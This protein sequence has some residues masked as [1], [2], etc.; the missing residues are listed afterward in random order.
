M[1]V[2]ITLTMTYFALLIGLGV[3]IANLLKKV[4]IPDTFFLLL[5]GL[6]IGP[7]VF[8]NPLVTQYIDMTLVNVE[9]MGAVP[10]FLRV[11]ALILV[12]FTGTFNLKWKIFQRFSNV[13]VNLAFLGVFFTTIFTGLFA[14]ILFGFD[15]IQSLLLGAV[16]SGTGTGVLIAFEKS[17]SKSKKAL[18]II[19]IESIFN[20]PLTVL[21]PILFL[22]LVI[23][24]PGAIISP[25]TYAAQ[26]WQ[27][28]VAGVGTG[29]I[30]GLIISK[31]MKTF[32]K[33]Y[34]SLALFSIALV[35]YALAE[36][37]GGSGMLAVAICGLMA[38]NFVF[39]DNDK[40]DVKQFDDQLSEMLRIAVF[41]ML[42]AQVVLPFDL[43]QLGT[44]F[45]FFLIVFAS[46]P[47]FLIPILGKRRKKF[48][49][50]DITLMCFVAPRG[51]AA[52]AMAPI[53]ASV[54]AS[55]GQ[56][57]AGDLIVNIIF[58]VVLMSVLFSTI[59]ATIMSTD[60][61]QNIGRKGAA[62]DPEQ[63]KLDEDDVYHGLEGKN[64]EQGNDGESSLDSNS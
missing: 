13:S 9:A 11:L 29:L 42:G 14:H 64:P 30:I 24:E 26:F 40:E 33:E 55:V 45:I 20:S 62:K 39:K 63:K 52:A 48:T 18:A 59:V 34:S 51:I 37:V 57:A 17:L 28:I 38:G 23:L 36:S 46:R 56:K 43:V 54:L 27:M 4:K 3:I 10:D 1:V 35:T 58:M 44:A 19:K 49:K 32:V 2:D 41:T 15:P 22:D 60:K 21:L 61:V 47:L 8:A 25:M 16:V 12:V 53:I 6:V 31:I 7:T 50:K 5:L